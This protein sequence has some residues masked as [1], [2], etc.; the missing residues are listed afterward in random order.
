MSDHY[1]PVLEQRLGSLYDVVS[2]RRIFKHKAQK[3][4]LITLFENLSVAWLGGFNNVVDFLHAHEK[5]I[6]RDLLGGL[7]D[8]GINT[9]IENMP[10]GWP[11]IPLDKNADIIMHALT[12]LRNKME[13][14]NIFDTE[15]QSL[16]IMC[17]SLL[18]ADKNVSYNEIR[19]NMLGHPY[20]IELSK[21]EPNKFNH[22]TPDDEL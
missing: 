17:M 2:L 12:F 8:R 16:L 11:T 4:I 1:T 13:E 19:R 22:L 5:T 10:E 6:T 3:E 20:F 21:F 7:G 14:D 9:I 18:R 15:G